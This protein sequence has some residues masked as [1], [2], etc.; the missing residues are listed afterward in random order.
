MADKKTLHIWFIP[1]FMKVECCKIC[2]IVK[3]RDGKNKPCEGKPKVGPRIAEKYN[4]LIMS[5]ET[6]V[7]GQSR[8][9][10]ALMHI[11]NG[12]HRGNSAEGCLGSR[13]EG[14]ME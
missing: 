6:K 11:K 12:E 8:H 7:P 2:G 9:E 10:T 4:E 14:E 3:R 5:V 13:T 1:D